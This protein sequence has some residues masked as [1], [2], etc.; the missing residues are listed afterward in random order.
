[1]DGSPLRFKATFGN[2]SNTL[3]L[4]K[5]LQALIKSEVPS[6]VEVR[7]DSHSTQIT[8]ENLPHIDPD[9]LEGYYSFISPE[10]RSFQ[11]GGIDADIIS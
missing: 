5:A 8:K 10:S 11:P 1:M 3:F 2:E 6:Q 7:S 9:V 4:R